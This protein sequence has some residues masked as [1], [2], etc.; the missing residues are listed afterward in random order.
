MVDSVVIRWKDQHFMVIRSQCC[1][2]DYATCDQGL[3]HS[4]A[5]FIV[6]EPS[7]LSYHSTI[8]TW[9][10]NNINTV[11]NHLA[12]ENTNDTLIRLPKQFIWGNYSSQIKLITGLQ[13]RDLQCRKMV[14]DIRVDSRPDKHIN[15]SLDAV[16]RIFFTTAKHCLKLRTLKTIYQ[17]IFCFF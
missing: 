15:S 7:S 3:F 17:I 2:I 5:N 9:L 8:M 4:I 13:T 11:N 16:E 10:I 1:C 12:T 6:K 14:L